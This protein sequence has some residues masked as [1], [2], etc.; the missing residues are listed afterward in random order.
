MRWTA[1]YTA[2]R[3]AAGLAHRIHHGR[4]CTALMPSGN[5]R[6]LSRTWCPSGRSIRTAACT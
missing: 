3:P 5:S 1:R 6:C 4:T 2:V